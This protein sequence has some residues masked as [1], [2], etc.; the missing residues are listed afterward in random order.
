MRKALL[1]I[2]MISIAGCGYERRDRHHRQEPN[3]KP[4][5]R[6]LI[7]DYGPHALL[8]YD[9]DTTMTITPPVQYNYSHTRW[10][11]QD[12]MIY[13]YYWNGYSWYMYW[14]VQCAS[15]IK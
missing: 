4:A 14:S 7:Q 10:H 13:A 8:E 15:L 12:S 5:P 3:R 6:R 1:I 11:M 2:A 9:D